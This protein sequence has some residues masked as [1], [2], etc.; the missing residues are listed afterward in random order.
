MSIV[1]SPLPPASLSFYGSRTLSEAESDFNRESIIVQS[2]KLPVIFEGKEMDLRFS[3]LNESD[4][5]DDEIEEEEES[6]F[7][8]IVVHSVSIVNVNP[9]AMDDN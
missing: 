3:T 5:F 9:G 8:P 6:A 4:V 7:G 1:F 2:P